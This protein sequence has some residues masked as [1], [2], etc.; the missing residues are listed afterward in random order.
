M[1]MC[2]P[3]A[4]RQP[5]SIGSCMAVTR[6]LPS[7]LNATSRCEPFHSSIS[8]SACAFGNQSETPL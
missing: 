6:K 3:S 7:G 5:C 2:L 8:G 1:R 4:I